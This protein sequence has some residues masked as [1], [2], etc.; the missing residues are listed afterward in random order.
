MRGLLSSPA[1]TIELHE[2]GDGQVRRE[3][4]LHGDRATTEARR[5]AAGRAR[6]TS[7]AL[8]TQHEAAT[9]LACEQSLATGPRPVRHP[10]STRATLRVLQG[11][12]NP[13]AG[14]QGRSPVRLQLV[15]A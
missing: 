15:T 1:G 12:G 11:G 2:G 14:R 9:L 6:Q 8:L 4:L 3:H 13:V 10:P 7:E 5:V